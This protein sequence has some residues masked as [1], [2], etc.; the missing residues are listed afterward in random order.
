MGPPERGLYEHPG[1]DADLGADQR[2]D[3]GFASG[4]VEA[5]GTADAVSVDQGNGRELELGGSLDEILGQ[6]G[7]AK[8]GEGGS[9]VQLRVALP[10]RSSG[11][12]SPI[13]ELL[14]ARARRDI[15]RG[16]QPGTDVPG[17]P[18]TW[19]HPG[20]PEWLC[21]PECRKKSRFRGCCLSPP[22]PRRDEEASGTSKKQSR[23]GMR[24]IGVSR[25]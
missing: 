10:C 25:A 24:S 13:F 17:R 11:A 23:K 7:T 3:P 22:E 18:P 1:S 16:V 21:H 19:P 9:A 12:V 4:L 14:F 6:G 5:W 8:E 2:L 20:L 15:V